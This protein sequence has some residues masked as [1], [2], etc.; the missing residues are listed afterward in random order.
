MKDISAAK[1]IHAQVTYPQASFSRRTVEIDVICRQLVRKDPHKFVQRF[2]PDV[3]AEKEHRIGRAG[4]SN[5]NIVCGPAHQ[6]NVDIGCG[7]DHFLT[8]DFIDIC[9]NKRR[10]KHGILPCELVVRVVKDRFPSGRISPARIE[11][12]LVSPREKRELGRHEVDIGLSLTEAKLSGVVAHPTME[13]LPDQLPVAVRRSAPSRG[14]SI[15]LCA[16]AP[17]LNAAPEA[18]P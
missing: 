6:P 12:F 11:D 15:Q 14:P 9:W 17:T 18:T 8:D 16:L 2:L 13:G 5:P 10:E 7:Y 4:V 1:L 3:T